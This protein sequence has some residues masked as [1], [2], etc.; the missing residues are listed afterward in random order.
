M[1]G[2]ELTAGSAT[3]FV[4]WQRSPQKNLHQNIAY[5][6]FWPSGPLQFCPDTGTAVDCLTAPC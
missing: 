4:L 1:Q 5:E 6:R 3:V 2:L